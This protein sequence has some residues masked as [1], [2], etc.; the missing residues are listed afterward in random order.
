MRVGDVLG[1]RFELERIAGEGGMGTV[2]R[3]RDLDAQGAPV[4]VKLMRWVGR[5]QE[6]LAERF[7]R[8]A[9]ALSTLSH[10]GIV[11]WLGHGQSASGRPWLAMEWLEG[12]ELAARLERQGLT[13]TEAV[14]LLLRVA[15][16]VAAAHVRGIVHRDIKPS[17][18]FLVTGD[19]ERVK[20]LDF[21]VAR[22][23]PLGRTMT[24]AGTAIGT[25]GYMAPEQV[26]GEPDVDSR[27]DVFA[28]GCVLFEC[29]TGRAAFVGATPIA[30]LAKILCEEAPRPSELVDVPPDLDAL[31]ARLLSK[32]RS[33]RPLDAGA[34]GA[35]LRALGAT[36]GSRRAPTRAVQQLGAREQRLVTVLLAEG[37]AL[38]VAATTAEWTVEEGPD[39]VAEIIERH[40]GRLD[41]L[42]EGTRVAVFE[43][44]EIGA[45]CALS[46]R[47]LLAGRRLSLSSGRAEVGARMPVGEAIDRAA[48]L[49]ACAEPGQVRLDALTARLVGGRYGVDG[50][51]LGAP[52]RQTAE[53]TLLGKA[54]PS[55]G[56]E[57]ELGLLEAA[58]RACSEEGTARA[59]VVSAAAGVGKSRLRREL[60]QRLG[61]GVEVWSAGGEPMGAGAALGLV[62]RMIRAQAGIAGGQPLTLGQARLR[63]WVGRCVPTSEADRVS[64]LLCEAASE[65]V[66]QEQA[67][68]LL[69]SARRDP[70]IM[71]DQVRRAFTDLVEAATSRGALVL[72]LEDLHWADAASVRLVD[73]ALRLC[74]ERPLMVLALGRPE[75]L[76]R[77]PALFESRGAQ[78]IK[79]A[80]LARR[81]AERL[82][83]AV[84]DADVPAERVAPIVERAAGNAFFLE[85]AD[86][87]RRRGHRRDTR[88]GAG[89]GARPHRANG[90]GAPACS[91]RCERLRRAVLA[92]RGAGVV[93]RGAIDRHRRLARGA[94]AARGRLT[95]RSRPL[96]ERTRV[97]VP[98]RARA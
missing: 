53:R 25:P 67:S 36:E 6:L 76:D 88:D 44:P 69:R 45:A 58:V 34:V 10:P 23:A 20:L 12:E 13:T 57:M 46:V 1:G 90:A 60:R 32:D 35:A 86:A 79:L 73:E 91:S 14:A 74:A 70:R 66:P 8:E 22:G 56:R 89:D 78:H 29:L 97:R 64:E 85:E 75:M 7:G 43:E 52:L 26:R 31:C 65:P 42:A 19:L 21:G 80:P 3:A 9:E 55:V 37:E 4:A 87:R 68:P 84:F 98:A 72:I 62:V 96:R 17:N 93:R 82:V 77:F 50:G 5:G 48:R 61:Q 28:L 11:R 83:R 24:R 49:L 95:A 54:T 59:L 30:V 27:M 16:A 18:I 47:A 71:A 33:E 92:R 15:E 41:A 81:A 2:W 51:V 39:P 40:G 38:S 94:G 63:Q